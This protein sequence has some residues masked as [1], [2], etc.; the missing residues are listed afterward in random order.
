MA[1]IN[2]IYNDLDNISV[3]SSYACSPEDCSKFINL[4]TS[5]NI[6][7]INIRSIN[8][9]F[10]DFNCLL[11]AMK[12]DCDILIL[13]ECWLKN[14]RSIPTVLGYTA[15]QTNNL[16]NQ[17]DGIVI[18][19]REHLSFTITEPQFSDSSCII[20]TIENK[21]A[22][23]ALYRSPSI[24]HI[25]DFLDSLHNVLLDLKHYHTIAV[26]GDTNINICSNSN[27]SRSE[28]YLNVVASHGLLPAHQL[29]TRLDNCLD[30]ILLKTKYK[31]TTLVLDT[32]ITDHSAVVLSIE[33]CNKIKKTHKLSLTRFNLP[34]AIK[35][36][37]CFDFSKIN[38]MLDPNLATNELISILSSIVIRNT[39]YRSIP[40]RARIIKPWITSGLLRCIRNRD[41]MHLKIKKE[42]ENSILKLTYLRYRNFCNNLLKKLK[43]EYEKQELLKAKNNPKKMWETIRKITDAKHN[44][45]LPNELLKLCHSPLKSVDSINLYFTQVGKSLSNSIIHTQ[46]S[47]QSSLIKSHT[48]LNSLVLLETDER[49]VERI[50]KELRTDSASGWDGISPKLLKSTSNILVP[51]I[52]HICNLCLSTGIFPVALKKA[53]VHPIFKSGDR[54][55]VNNYRPISVLPAIS[56][57][58]ERILYKNLNNYVN[59][60]KL[61]SQNQYG[62]RKGL[63]TED[64]VSALLNY[65]VDKIDK[66]QKCLGLFLDLSKAFDTVSVPVL[67]SK[68]ESVGVRGTALGIF[69]SFLSDRVQCVKV[70]D[71]ISGDESIEFGVPQGS[72]ISPLLFSIYVND[73][74]EL[75]HPFAKVVAYADDTAIITYGHDWQAATDIAEAVLR[76]VTSWL[77]KNSLTLNV[78]KTNLVTFSS[79][80]STQPP[81]HAV[82]IRI[83]RCNTLDLNCSCPTVN[84]VP[85]VKYLGLQLDA[86]LS[87]KAHLQTLSA[88][89][90]KLIFVFKKLRLAAHTNTLNMVYS[91]LCE[92]IV[93]YCITAWG[94]STKTTIIQV[95]RAQR[96][97]IKVLLGKPRRYPTSLLYSEH[98][99]LSVRQTFVL[100]TVL[101]KHA[102]LPPPDTI[103]AI[104]RRRP[105][106]ACPN[107]QVHSTFAQR[108]YPYLSSLLYNKLHTTLNIHSLNTYQ[109]KHKIKEYLMSLD[110]DDTEELIKPPHC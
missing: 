65:V 90:R 105:I 78:E 100:R 23:I 93:G 70:G 7:H 11:V 17:N 54:G 53:L 28:Q 86:C 83:H 41:K 66:K 33:P 24:I 29:P 58:L 60:Y 43:V 20:C 92:S 35:D 63:S 91:A 98:K 110:Y 5:F 12:I 48:S 97:V 64:A 96:A 59:K 68:L 1:S 2:E 101:R 13:T 108:H 50:I 44:S 27:D 22:I 77:S 74:C 103:R 25:D 79:R 94:G 21:M 104:R 67:L 15:H 75:S 6:L 51:P 38:T 82:L 107:A 39:I 8:K 42:P 9:N 52:T 71:Y 88:R 32:T 106:S 16:I 76:Q 36:I 55:C 62:F 84:R 10:N 49:E 37:E 57:I 61:I 4:V 73:L 95:E 19:I 30:H 40:C 69:R 99:T 109:C 47:S 45:P 72:L 85:V 80:P 34:N 102:S 87:W 26:I 89:I 46:N 3:S 56:K 14:S 81:D 31:A 18:Y